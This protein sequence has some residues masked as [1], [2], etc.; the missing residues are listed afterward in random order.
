MMPVESGIRVPPSMPTCPI[1]TFLPSGATPGGMPEVLADSGLPVT[2]PEVMELVSQHP[3]IAIAV[4]AVFGLLVG[5]LTRPRAAK[6]R[7]APRP[8]PEGLEELRWRHEKL[9]L[10]ERQQVEK[11]SRLDDFVAGLDPSA[12]GLE[13]SLRFQ[14]FLVSERMREA[15][16]KVGSD[17]SRMRATRER[18]GLILPSVERGRESVEACRGM[19]EAQAARLEEARELLRELADE[20]RA[21]EESVLVPGPLADPAAVRRNFMALKGRILTLPQGWATSS[22][23]TDRRIRELLATVDHPALGPVREIL[24]VDGALTASLAGAST[25]DLTGA[26][27]AVI[28]ALDRLASAKETPAPET[29]TKEAPV[30]EVATE[31]PATP[32]S[33][34]PESLFTSPANAEIPL[35]FG[36]PE[37]NQPDPAFRCPSEFTPLAV[38]LSKGFRDLTQGNTNGNGKGL[39]HGPE[40][41]AGVEVNSTPAPSALEEG[42]DSERTLVLFCSNNVE[43]WGQT[44]YRGA[45]CRARAIAEFPE[46]ARWISIRRLD[47]NERVFAPILTASL[48]TGQVSD[49]FGFNGTNELFYGARHLGLFSETCP[50]EV[51]T[52]FTY[53]GWGFGHRAHEIAPEVEQLQAA[54]WEGREIPADT[55]FEIVIHEELPSL[56]QRDRILEG[57]VRGVR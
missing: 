28:A 34:L 19:A 41:A 23:E 43:L 7:E 17:L 6:D 16:Q 42:D 9:V 18:L 32:E 14:V 36:F 46:W 25:L 12:G 35:D 3:L 50:N 10:T 31:S 29:P 13:S 30:V 57:E 11:Q 15:R 49:P 55:V 39:A 38:R 47:T 24:L 20:A 40:I 33:G 44:V 45:R 4:A 56:G 22:E 37:S 27:S 1:H 51:E 48:R 5:W 8:E 52:R 54:G 2:L 26:V 53:G 21:I